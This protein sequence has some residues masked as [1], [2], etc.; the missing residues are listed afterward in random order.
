VAP[1]NSG[2]VIHNNNGIAGVE[3]LDRLAALMRRQL[4]RS[5]EPDAAHFGSLAAFAG[6]SP[7]ECPLEFGEAAEDR[8]H[9]HHM[10][11]GGIAPSILE[12]AEAGAGLLHRFQDIQQVAGGAGQPVEPGHHQHVTWL[13]PLDHPGELGSIAPRAA[14]L[15]RINLGASRGPQLGQLTGQVLFAGA[16]TGVSEVHGVAFFCSRIYATINP[17]IFRIK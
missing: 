11:S 4:E 10:G 15:L 7:D 2:Q 8:Q 1:W 5:A 17:R 13:E 6:P 9:Q 14:R 12:R 16:H 3:P